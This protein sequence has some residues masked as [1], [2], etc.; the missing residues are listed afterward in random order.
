MAKFLAYKRDDRQVV[1]VNTIDVATV[2]L[3]NQ[4]TGAN[5][6]SD[7]PGRTENIVAEFRG[8]YYLLYLTATNEVSLSVFDLGLNTW[9]DVV[10]FNSFTTGSGSLT[11]VCLHVVRDRLVAI[12]S[13][14][15]SAGVDG[16]LAQR[17]AADDGATWSPIVTQNFVTQPNPSRAGAS[18]VW[19]NAV[20][21]TTAEGICYYD[22]A[23]DTIAAAFDS[24]DDTNITDPKANF[25]SFTFLEGDLYYVLPT[26][27]VAGAPTLYKLDKAWSTTTP[28][29]PPAWTLQPIII[30]GT[31][32]IVVNNDTGNY[33]LFVNRNGDMSLA[34]SGSLGSKLVTIVRSGS[35]FVVTD[36]ST[37]LLPDSIRT[38]P[39]LGFGYYVDDRRSS[40]ERH[41][42]I[43]RFRPAI[44]QSI[45]LL[46]WDGVNAV[47]ESG[48]LDDGGSGL[49]LMCPDAER[50][51]TRT[52]TANE[53]S[54]FL[55]DASQPFPGRV[56]IDYTVGDENSRNVDVI[57]EFSIDGQSWT[58]MSKGD[59]DSGVTD[60]MT[61]P[62][63]VPYFFFWDA[64]SDL[65]G[66]HDN[67]DIRVVARLSGV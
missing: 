49:D 33:S 36:V 21:F 3:G 62:T 22:P 18:V 12:V 35:S 4:I 14:S 56:R 41:T 51:D 34:Y 52:Y 40:N 66:D 29:T 38:E 60:L 57:P 54:C 28:I 23:G 64:F 42:I 46:D 16:I 67:I 17:S 47:I 13:L 45:V 58:A 26:T 63:G 19:H 37:T 39:N 55:D 9:S 50:G 61:T 32:E 25:G 8:S 53:P 2:A 15:N 10:G 5:V 11:P 43:V 30:P 65:N 44:P 31:G 6:L 48:V 59:G 20:F 24:G 27:L 7:F 1:T